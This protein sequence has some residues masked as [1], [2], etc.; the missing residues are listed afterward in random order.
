MKAMS[1]RQPNPVNVRR[2]DHLVLRASD[3]ERLVAFYT[4]V[5]GC[6]LE[7]RSG[8]GNMW[9]VRAGDSLI[10]VLRAAS[11]GPSAEGHLDHF[12]L[13]VE[14]WDEARI[15]DHLRRHG[16]VV[17]EVLRRYGALGHGPSIYFDDPEGNTVELKGR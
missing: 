14:P 2:I 1:H 17:D 8:S 5:L 4:D 6:R 11:S 16:V 9:Q 7:R 3:P 15:V 12:C 13:Y 10:D